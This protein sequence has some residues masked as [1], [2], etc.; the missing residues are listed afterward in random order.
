MGLL[1][2]AWQAVIAICLLIVL[3]LGLLKLARR[4]PTRMTNAM[5]VTAMVIVAITALTV[6]AQ[7]L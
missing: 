6:A 5:L 1:S 2:P 4:G 3:L 7:L